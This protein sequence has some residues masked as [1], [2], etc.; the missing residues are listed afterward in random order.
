MKSSKFKAL[1]A[2]VPNEIKEKRTKMNDH[3]AKPA[4]RHA[5]YAPH[6]NTK[7][8]WLNTLSKDSYLTSQ[9][10]FNASSK[11]EIRMAKY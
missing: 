6:L 8:E 11:Y 3:G 9:I 10:S 1:G 7:Y 2:E 4:M 5:G